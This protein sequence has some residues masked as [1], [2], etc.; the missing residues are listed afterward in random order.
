MALAALLTACN[1][2]SRTQPP[3][4]DDDA[5]RTQV[6]ET[7]SAQLTQVNAGVITATPGEFSPTVLPTQT[8]SPTQEAT[9]TLAPTPTLQP[10]LPP[11][12]TTEARLVYEDDFS[13]DDGFWYTETNDDFGFKYVD[14][15]Y[16]IYVNILNAP[17]WSIREVDINDVIVEV[18]AALLEGPEDG[19]YGV[20]CR[21]QGEDDYYSLVISPDG[22]YGIAKMENGE[23]EFLAEG[24]DQ[25]GIIHGGD[26]SNR[27]RG[28]CIG[29]TLTLFANGQKLLEVNDDD[30]LSGD[31]GLLAGTRLSGGIEVLF[32]YFAILEP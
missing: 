30:L 16:Q 21:H 28:E 18:E 17:I 22:S 13:D 20:V 5:I 27:V 7:I 12:P 32:T 6:A 25:S 24:Q 15:G 3:V 1:L 31:V 2:P 19:Y 29:E 8:P 4:E 9:K 10:T 26:A 23:Y 11:A 14:D